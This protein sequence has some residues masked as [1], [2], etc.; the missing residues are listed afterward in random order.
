MNAFGEKM[1][2]LPHVVSSTEKALETS[3]M[4]QQQGLI[5]ATRSDGETC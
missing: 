5:G 2:I 3:S 1:S 4:G